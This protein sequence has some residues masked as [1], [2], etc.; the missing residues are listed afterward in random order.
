MRGYQKSQAVKM[1][2]E[3]LPREVTEK[4]VRE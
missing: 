3:N 4:F 1:G 2:E